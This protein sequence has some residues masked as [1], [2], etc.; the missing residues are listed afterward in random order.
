M[1]S[2]FLCVEIK[3][4]YYSGIQFYETGLIQK[5]LE[6]TGMNNFNGLATPTKV[7]A[8]LGIYDNVHEA[9]RYWPNSYFCVIEIMSYLAS[10]IISD[11]FFAVHMCATHNTKAYHE[12]ALK[13]ICQYLHGNQVKGSSV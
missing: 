7:E 2:D 4:L 3:K 13:R 11:I 8:P 9:K 10:N 5:V 1:L 6:A 12:T